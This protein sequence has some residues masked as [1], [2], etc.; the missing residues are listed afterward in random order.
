M[1]FLEGDIHSGSKESIFKSIAPQ[2]RSTSFKGVRLS[3]G[4]FV[5]V[6]ER[7]GSRIQ[8]FKEGGTCSWEL[9]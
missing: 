5:S 2:Q 8:P 6:V 4:K 1:L 7:T 9:H 3:D